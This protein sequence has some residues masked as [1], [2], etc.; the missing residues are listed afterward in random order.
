MTRSGF[1]L[2]FAAIVQYGSKEFMLNGRTM[3]WFRAFLLILGMAAA[4]PV[5]YGAEPVGS[6]Q[7][8]QGSATATLDGAERTLAAG[9]PVNLAET[10]VTG[11]GSRAALILNDGTT[12][13]LGEKARLVIDA[14]VY[15][16]AA[17]STLHASVTGAFRYLSGRLAP[18]ATR[19]ASVT[20]PVATIGVRG[21]DFWGGPIDG[22]FGVV[23]FE[24]AVSVTVGGQT[25][26]LD[27]GGLGANFGG[28]AAMS[29]TRWPQD[30]VARALATVTFGP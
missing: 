9:A 21:T 17:A 13:T 25:V 30:K 3:A 2:S 8:L 16:P 26:L 24:G 15:D 28:A 11:A 18:G 1:H 20:T 7:R 6:V 23:L 14:F 29:V 10:V 22:R 5:A 4:T 12:I 19:Q 27:A